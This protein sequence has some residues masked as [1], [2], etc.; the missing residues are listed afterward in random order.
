MH[1]TVPPPPQSNPQSWNFKSRQDIMSQSM[2]PLYFFFASKQR[3][4]RSKHPVREAARL[5]FRTD[6]SPVLSASCCPPLALAVKDEA[7]TGTINGATAGLYR[8][9]TPPQCSLMQYHT[10]QAIVWALILCTVRESGPCST[11]TGFTVPREL[12][13]PPC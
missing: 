9:K 2:S 1:T 10:G 7:C 8:L 3:N 11:T 13:H 6:Y 5:L 4:T 12:V